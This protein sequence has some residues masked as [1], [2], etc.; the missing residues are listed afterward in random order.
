M[1]RRIVSQREQFSPAVRIVAADDFE[2][3]IDLDHQESVNLAAMDLPGKHRPA[4]RAWYSQTHGMTPQ[5]ALKEFKKMGE[6]GIKN[7]SPGGNNYEKYSNPA[8]KSQDLKDMGAEAGDDWDNP[9]PA[10]GTSPYHNMS[11]KDALGQEGTFENWVAHNPFY[12]KKLN[13][14]PQLMEKFKNHLGEE[15]WEGLFQDALQ[16]AAQDGNKHA[17]ELLDPHR[18]DEVH[19]EWQYEGDTPE[20]FTRQQ[21][22]A[23][24]E[25]VKK[26]LGPYYK[27]DDQQQQPNDVDDVMDLL[28]PDPWGQATIQDQFGLEPD[29][30]QM[31]LKE[32]L[33]A[34]AGTST[35]MDWLNSH[36]NAVTALQDP[37][38]PAHK[39]LV[40]QIGPQLAQHLPD[41][42]S[43]NA[44]HN[45]LAKQ[46]DEATYGSDPGGMEFWLNNPP[47]GNSKKMKTFM[48]WAAEKNLSP[49]QQA[50][51]YK[52][53]FP[54]YSGDGNLNGPKW[55][56][57]MAEQ[58]AGVPT[59]FQQMAKGLSGGSTPAPG[60][61]E[62]GHIPPWAK[63]HFT[64]P[65]VEYPAFKA[66]RMDH[67]EVPSA[68]EA[69]QK[70]QDLSPEDK[71]KIIGLYGSPK[72]PTSLSDI[73]DDPD[74]EALLG[75]SD[76]DLE[77]SDEELK[78]GYSSEFE[79]LL[80]DVDKSLSHL[81]GD[82][83]LKQFADDL[84]IPANGALETWKSW[85][86]EKWKTTLDKAAE[87][88][89]G[90]QWQNFAEKN[91]PG[92]L[93]TFEEEEPGLWDQ[94]KAKNPKWIDSAD[95]K[96]L[97][98][99]FESFPKATQNYWLNSSASM[100]VADWKD[101]GGKHYEHPGYQDVMDNAMNH[102]GISSADFSLMTEPEFKNWYASLGADSVPLAKLPSEVLSMFKNSPE[103]KKLTGG[104]LSSPGGLDMHKNPG[105]EKWMKDTHGY[106]PNT[107]QHIVDQ[108]APGGIYDVG[109]PGGKHNISKYMSDYVQHLSQSPQTG[110]EPALKGSGDGNLNGPKWGDAVDSPTSKK[111]PWSGQKFIEEYEDIF[112]GGK[113]LLK[114]DQVDTPEKAQQMLQETLDATEGMKSYE[115]DI[116]KLQKMM[117]THFGDDVS[118]TGYSPLHKKLEKA[119][120][121]AF[122]STGDN[123]YSSLFG[124][125]EPEELQKILEAE[126]QYQSPS[127][128]QHTKWKNVLKDVFGTN[129]S[130]HDAPYE[131]P[132]P[133]GNVRP[134]R[135]RRPVHLDSPLFRAEDRPTLPDGKTYISPN[136]WNPPTTSGARPDVRWDNNDFEEDEVLPGM[137][138]ENRS[139]KIYRGEPIDLS[140]PD[141][142]KLRSLIMGPLHG[143]NYYRDYSPWFDY[144]SDVEA[145][146]DAY[147][148]LPGMEVGIGKPLQREKWQGPKDPVTGEPL[149][150]TPHHNP[151]V[152]ME[153]LRHWERARQDYNGNEHNDKRY[154]YPGR[155]DNSPQV[156][157][158]RH[159]TVDPY[160]AEQ[161]AGY[162][163][164]KTLPTRF[165]VEHQG[166]GEDPYR[167]NTGGEF[168]SE[169][170]LTM[171]PGGRKKI[172]DVQV[173]HPQRGW[174]S[175]WPEGHSE[176]HYSSRR[177]AALP[178][179]YDFEY[180]PELNRARINHKTDGMASQLTWHG[181]GEVK[182]ISTEPEH[183]GK[184]LAKSLFDMA[185]EQHPDLH[186]SENLTGQGQAWVQKHWPTEFDFEDDSFE[187]D[188]ND[189]GEGSF[190]DEWQPSPELQETLSR[191]QETEDQQVARIRQEW[192]DHFGYW[193]EEHGRQASLTFEA[194]LTD[195]EWQEHLDHYNRAIEQAKDQGLHTH[196]QHAGP[197]NGWTPERFE[198]HQQI[199]DDAWE[200]LG[201]DSI[202]KNRQGLFVGGLPASGKT[203]VLDHIDDIPGVGPY[204]GNYLDNDN[205]Y[206]KWQLVRRGMAPEIPGLSPMETAELLHHEADHLS[207]QFGLR[208]MAQGTNMAHHSTMRYLPESRLKGFQDNDY[209]MN[210]VFMHST[211]EESLAGAQGRYRAQ[212]EE[213]LEGARPHG[214][215]PVPESYISGSAS[216][217]PAYPSENHRVFDQELTPHLA[218]PPQ[219]WRAGQGG[220]PPQR[221]V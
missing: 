94:W 21:D 92:Y 159:W 180:E 46:Q 199:L 216:N 207:K 116:P 152:G 132:V 138:T 45:T 101:S 179:D 108:S 66:W 181:N 185:Q 113:N 158:G 146:P 73:F 12:I 8:H 218:N 68:N 95:E 131:H 83:V 10:D 205:D 175:S 84:C 17:Y 25:A 183:G 67:H 147:P 188:D 150:E 59:T 170:E 125:A 56:D 172:V 129:K 28:K 196:Y 163:G 165:V 86:P 33:D 72:T 219:V 23:D 34:G 99:Y 192:Y 202:P 88:Q 35:V 120:K 55:F 98:P 128:I 203:G 69:L 65:E 22:E 77:P 71:Q 47:L 29:I 5:Q 78:R 173:K 79:D 176:Y 135:E 151:E 166:T 19:E 27:D 167:T 133:E 195:D 168:S 36:P 20:W 124:K 137:P 48:G 141:A 182:M 85:T 121:A 117:E 208:A 6:Q 26:A 93:G 51:L 42:G 174:I 164:D 209:T 221:M 186:H 122:P 43:W 111:K 44:L 198:Q 220:S 112:P 61:G 217:D 52:S 144:H 2:D 60:P 200:E 96:K 104:G 160:Q 201:G 178:P 177:T 161:W 70:W 213:M 100:L 130:T 123:T 50:K 11:A 114:E 171:V 162:P 210:G 76:R 87:G 189:D 30:N 14:D 16:S 156:G 193:P 53:F 3:D 15:N 211:P 215:R 145:N 139:V 154:R 75:H 58:V 49:Q 54:K 7:W 63:Q 106:E 126:I 9:A 90:S 97:K 109:A 194:A 1:S 197:M 212:H 148:P 32:L 57:A 39:D 13:D 91:A 64:N 187:D 214:G 143:D 74:S 190:G 41:G 134:S 24:G 140:H 142:A 169:K 153:A 191:P 102:P 107:I 206:F 119:V 4:F 136:D 37:Q 184:G 80:P 204:R 40:E 18:Q 127:T 82:D 118:Y 155:T 62:D 38:N 105:F 149:Y 31:T 81:P 115:N 110:A 157:L 89:Y 103:Y